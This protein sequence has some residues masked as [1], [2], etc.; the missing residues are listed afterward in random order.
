MEVDA[1]NVA[2]TI[3]MKLGFPPDDVKPSFEVVSDG[4]NQTANVRLTVPPDDGKPEIELATDGTTNAVRVGMSTPP[5]D[6][7][8]AVELMADA[9]QNAVKVNWGS[10]PDDSR[11]GI[12]MYADNNEN[13]LKVNWASPPDDV[14]PAFEVL[15]DGVAGAVNV[16]LAAPPDDSK[17]EIELASDGST[18]RVSVGLSFPPDDIIPTV[19]LVSNPAYASLTVAGASSTKL[20]DPPTIIMNAGLEEAR[21][22]IGTETPAQALD[23]KGTAEVEGFKMPTGASNGYVMTSDAEG[24]GAWQAQS[25]GLF[26]APAWESGWIAGGGGNVTLTHN[27]GVN[28]NNYVIDLQFKDTDNGYGIN[29]LGLG[30]VN[31]GSPSP[32]GGYYYNLD[33][34]FISLYSIGNQCDSIRVRIW[35]TQ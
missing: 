25:S 6:G 28:P 35:I 30:L 26:P 12:E 8:P 32:N 17:P 31:H 34:N 9:V 29:M 11:T 2:Q 1:D 22:G 23:V 19:E 20:A 7:M 27:L 16:R 24:N 18:N 5:D 13:A 33:M 10:P 4:F 15:S 14:M 3:S 21:V